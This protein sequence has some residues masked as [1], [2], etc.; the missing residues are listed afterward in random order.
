M[1]KRGTSLLLVLLTALPV[2]P[3]MV[4][5]DHPALANYTI[6]DV[7]PNYHGAWL[8]IDTWNGKGMVITHWK[9]S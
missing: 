2:L 8:N 5:D 9:A 4:G 3:A 7:A 1:K 6:N